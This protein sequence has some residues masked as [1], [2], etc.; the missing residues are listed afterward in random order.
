[1]PGAEDKAF[2]LMLSAMNGRVT[3]SEPLGDRTMWL[4]TVDL[5]GE[6][7][8]AAGTVFRCGDQDVV[9]VYFGDTATPTARAVLSSARCD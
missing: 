8:G 2:A 6:A 7:T 3:G 4:G 9:A 5:E 1:M